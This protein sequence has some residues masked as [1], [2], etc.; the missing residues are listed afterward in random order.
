MP[1]VNRTGANGGVG[2]S[3]VANAEPNGRTLLLGPGTLFTISPL[4]FNEMPVQLDQLR[5]ILGLAQVPF[6]MAVRADSPWETLEDHINDA[7]SGTEITY[8]HSGTGGSD[9]TLRALYSLAEVASNRSALW[10]WF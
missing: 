9:F 6:F 4:F 3:S 7:K 1:V 10:R 8:G 5:V 2:T